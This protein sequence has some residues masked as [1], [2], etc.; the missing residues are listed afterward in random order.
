MRVIFR[1]PRLAEFVDPEAAL[2]IVTER[3]RE[4]DEI[5]II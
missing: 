5:M 2:G 1:G 3:E 4:R